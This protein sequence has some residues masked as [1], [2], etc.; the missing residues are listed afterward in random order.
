MSK[1]YKPAHNYLLLL[2]AESSEMSSGGLYLPETARNKINEG[3]I[4][5]CGPTA[6]AFA[7]GQT[8]VFKQHSEYVVNIEKKKHVV[9]STDDIILFTD[10]PE[11]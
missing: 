3:T 10:K 6:G 9:V 8:V 2:P 5:A 7:I 11:A 4:V 1:E